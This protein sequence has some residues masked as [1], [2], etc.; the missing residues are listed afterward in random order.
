MYIKEDKKK[1]LCQLRRDKIKQHP[2]MWVVFAACFCF[3]L[4]TNATIDDTSSA[5]WWKAVVVVLNNLCYG[6]VA[7]FIFYVL[8][9]FMPETRKE[10]DAVAKITT[11]I[12]EIVFYM[13]S[14]EEIILGDRYE[15][16]KNDSCL[17]AAFLVRDSVPNIHFLSNGDSLLLRLDPKKLELVHMFTKRMYEHIS[18]LTTIHAKWLEA[19][20][21]WGLQLINGILNIDSSILDRNNLVVNSVDLRL[22]CTNYY[23]GKNVLKHYVTTHDKYDFLR[24]D[25][26]S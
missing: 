11:D 1:K 6:Y 8:S 17:L 4:L 9:Q 2:K 10:I 26:E 12:K 21:H 19:D 5:S 13:D 14:M 24:I 15:K 20:M 16:D 18:S 3:A 22:S 23:M 7:G 25:E